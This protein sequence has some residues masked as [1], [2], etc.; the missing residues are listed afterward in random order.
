[1]DKNINYSQS[2]LNLMLALVSQ[3]LLAVDVTDDFSTDGL[4][5]IHG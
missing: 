2:I 3:K 4:K 5:N 1:M